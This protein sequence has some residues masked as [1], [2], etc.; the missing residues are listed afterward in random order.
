MSQVRSTNA[1]TKPG[2]YTF[3]VPPGVSGAEL[4]LWGAGGAAGATGA[5]HTYVSGQAVVGSTTK[6]SY[7][8]TNVPGTPA[9]PQVIPG[10]SATYS[11]AG[12]Y[13]VSLPPGVTTATV[14][15]TPATGGTR[16]STGKGY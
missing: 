1:Y 3:T 12:T 14:V 10:G 8:P 16:S 9:L 5:T 4:F 13:A 15:T 2:I 6:L 11:T 7:V